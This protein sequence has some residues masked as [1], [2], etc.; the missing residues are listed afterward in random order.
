MF[1]FDRKP[2]TVLNKFINIV[3]YTTIINLSST[4]EGF[5]LN[6]N[7]L[8]GFSIDRLCEEKRCARVR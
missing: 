8:R 5:V 7:P 6:R 1:L 4:I 3:I 2:R